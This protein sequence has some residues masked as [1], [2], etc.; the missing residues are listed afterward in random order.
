[1]ITNL[2]VTWAPGRGNYCGDRYRWDDY[3]KRC[4]W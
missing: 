1:V 2:S 4:V 3:N